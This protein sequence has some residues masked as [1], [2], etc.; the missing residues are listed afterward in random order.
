MKNGNELSSKC[1]WRCTWAA[2]TLNPEPDQI[3]KAPKLG[4]NTLRQQ[5]QVSSGGKKLRLCFSNE[6]SETLDPPNC[7]LELRS[8]HIARLLKPGEPDIDPATDVEVTFDGKKSVKIPAGGT[9]TSDGADF[10]CR[11]LDFLAVSVLF[12]EGPEF[13]ACH[14]EADCSSWTASGNKVSE[15]FSP[16][17]F[18]WSYFSLCRAD[19]LCEPEVETLV[20]FGDSITDGAVS[21]FNGFDAWPSL[22]SQGLKADPKTSHI[23]VVNTSIAGNAIFGGWGTPARERFER[24]VINIPG[25]SRA[26]ILIGTNDIPG[27]QTDTSEAMINEYK[28]MIAACHKNGVKVYG[29][30]ITPFGK[31]EWWASEL[32]EKIRKTVNAWMMSPDSGFDGYVD[33]ASAVCDPDD[34]TRLA[35]END[36]GDGLHPS[37]AGHH[38]MGGKAVSEMKK[39][40]AA[41]K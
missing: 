4:G 24:D 36:S 20:C 26:L 28:A 7:G 15:N 39:I 9:V 38:A 17:E 32:H 2:A 10:D 8:V 22:L 16:E 41:E 6:Y 25:V 33:F 29:G 1:E 12:G 13:L 18:K 11:S 35:A 31:N 3:P 14:R 19:V 30:T 21:T 27:A 23:S 34:E 5:L 40:I 37:P